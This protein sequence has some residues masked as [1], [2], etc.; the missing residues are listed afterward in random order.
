P[1]S[2]DL[3]ALSCGPQISER[4]FQG[5]FPF[6]EVPDWQVV[7]TTSPSDLI[8]KNVGMGLVAYVIDEAG[9]PKVT[10]ETL[11]Q[12]IERLARIPFAEKMYIRLNWKDLQKEPGKLAPSEAW[13]LTFEMAAKYNKR[14]GFRVMLQNP[15][16]PGLAFP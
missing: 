10:G 9:P 12:S 3:N 7:M 5:P 1:S 6:Q 13:R 8:L 14:I 15:H 4:L 2:R 16:I 11:E